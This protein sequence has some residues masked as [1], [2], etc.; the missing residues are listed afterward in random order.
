[1]T[2]ITRAHAV[3]L[4]RRAERLGGGLQRVV[5]DIPLARTAPDLWP[6]S[7]SPLPA[8]DA[9]QTHDCRWPTDG[10]EGL[11]AHVAG[12]RIRLH[13]DRVDATR[14]PLRHIVA[15]TA[16]WPG[17][18]AGA[19]CCFALTGSPAVALAGAALGAL[20]GARRDHRPVRVIRLDRLDPGV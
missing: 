9:G 6:C 14:H 19:T 12:D 13:L 7:P 3:T 5:L 15:D 2:L 20:I 4:I 18:I 11:H 8:V 16:L 10:P 17:A 1:M